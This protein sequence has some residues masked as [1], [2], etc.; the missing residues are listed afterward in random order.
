MMDTRCVS[1]STL[2]ILADV[3]CIDVSK[4][5][6]SCGGCMEGQFYAPNATAGLE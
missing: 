6:E 2:Y 4:E 3:Q 5:L 1:P